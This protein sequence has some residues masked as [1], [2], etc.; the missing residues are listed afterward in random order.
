M[1][2]NVPAEVVGKGILDGGGDQAAVG[3]HMVF[4]AVLADIAQEFLQVLYFKDTVSAEGL[5]LVVR[6]TAFADIG[7][8]LTQLVV[9]GDAREGEGTR[10]DLPAK[11]AVGVVL[12]NG[13]GD[14]VL[15]LHLCAAE[16]GLG[17]VGAMEQD[18]LVGIRAEVIV[19]VEQGGRGTAGGLEGDH[20]DETADI[21]FAGGGDEFLGEHTH[22]GAG[23]DAVKFFQSA[24]ALQANAAQLLIL[25]PVIHADTQLSHLEEVFFGDSGH[26]SIFLER[27]QLGFDFRFLV[28]HAANPAEEFG[29]VQCFHRYTAGFQQFF[30]VAD[31]VESRRTG[32]ESAHAEVFQPGDD[33]AGADELFQVIGKG[34]A[35]GG[36]RV[37]SGEGIVYPVLAQ[38]IAAAHLAAEAVAAV[39]DAQFLDII[40]PGMD[41][42]G[43][44]QV[45]PAED[46]G[47]GALVTEVGQSH[48]HAF[49]LIL[50]LDE[51]IGAGPR[52]IQVL[53]R[54]EFGSCVLREDNGFNTLFLQG[55][56]NFGATLFTQRRREKTARSNNNT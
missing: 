35:V 30:A 20:A 51:E 56:Q 48:H 43:D 31:G 24:P 34:L 15:V 37:Q 32:T 13:A 14:D 7:F 29:E 42:N 36:I 12:A 47:D 54:S 38:I 3:G 26:I 45:G 19:P 50:V 46:V 9:G 53:H 52:F 44:V 1:A 27:V 33:F 25:D 22:H 55:F 2:I 21:R 5:Q 6:E 40:A 11:G 18:A 4:K 41:Q 17:Q 49:D 23:D 28:F 39:L 10:R 8:D 16:E